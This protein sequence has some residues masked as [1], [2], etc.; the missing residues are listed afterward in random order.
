LHRGDAAVIVKSRRRGIV[1]A[2][3][4]CQNTHVRDRNAKSR[5][6]LMRVTRLPSGLACLLS[7]RKRY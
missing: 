4:K 5:E 6:R 1:I 7:S 3:M 2:R